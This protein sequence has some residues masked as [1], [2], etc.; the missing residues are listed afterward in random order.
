M[1]SGAL[2]KVLG[3]A[4]VVLVP[5]IPV[6]FAL[7]AAFGDSAAWAHLSQTLVLEYAFNTA[8]VM[9]A[10]TVL[11]SLIGTAAAWLIASARFP[12]DRTF[13]WLLAMP[14]AL[15][16][17]VSAYAWAD[18]AGAR[19]IWIAV[20]VYATTL[21][22]YVYLAAR[23]AFAAQSVCALEAARNLGAGLVRRF[24]DVAL[25]LARPAI[26]GGAAL[27]ALEIAADYG[28]ADHLGVP[29]LTVGVFRAWFSMGD[30]A[31]AARLAC[32]TLL[33]ALALVAVERSLRLGSV[34]GGSTRWREARKDTLKGPAALAAIVSVC[35]VLA[36]ALA[37]P[38]GKLAQL[39]LAHGVPDRGLVEPLVST[40]ILTALGAAA[41]LAL[42]V[43]GA[44]LAR[45]SRT[46]GPRM[47]AIVRFSALAGYATPGAVTAL[48][49]LGALAMLGPGAAAG[50]SGW[51]G[52][53]MLVA[54]YAARFAAAGLE[55]VSAG[56]EKTTRSQREAATGLG[57]GPMR[58]FAL[59]D[60]PLA[61]PSVLAAALV[62]A[63]EI[64]KE[65]P[66]TTILR[67]LGFDT[68]AVRAHAY[69]ADERLGAAAWPALIIVALSALPAL[70]LARGIDKARAGASGA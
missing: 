4:V 27:V 52:L 11:A 57:C 19:G 33:I 43:T 66:A 26:A 46:S 12:G 1:S 55:P 64:A 8:V 17:Y 61:A 9:V 6:A 35:T 44:A 51:L 34:A 15:P 31:A 30:L 45:P 40:A 23:A 60:L 56:L 59:L 62:V 20:L 39:A 53:V 3:L 14:L 21:Y 16:A 58:R 41:T 10:A 36:V 38:V 32:I 67:P 22:P 7:A 54:A 25:P 5:G 63:I 48:G 50:L 29:T 24:T 70:L 68:L 28:A 47:A 65:L 42:A 49:F 2:L 18:I 37:L 69:A 13:G